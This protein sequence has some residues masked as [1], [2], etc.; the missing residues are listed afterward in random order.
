M[1]VFPIALHEKE[2]D[3]FCSIKDK[4]LQVFSLVCWFQFRE[5]NQPLIFVIPDSKI[6]NFKG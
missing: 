4:S 1:P 5:P 2:N 3:F 6:D